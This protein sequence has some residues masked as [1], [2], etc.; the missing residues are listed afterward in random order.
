MWSFPA[1]FGALE[2]VPLPLTETI[3]I[4]R[5]LP[6]PEIHAYIN[7]EPL[8]DL[9]DPDTPAPIATDESG[10]SDQLFLMDAIARRGREER[11]AT[12]RGRDIYATS[13]PIVVEAAERI[14][15]GRI[16]RTGAVAAGEIFDAHDFLEALSNKHLTVDIP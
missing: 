10:R 12:A 5:H 6:T 2:V 11:R 16:E 1:P 14:L 7:L 13:A 3:T 4:S 8:G 15:D 9:R